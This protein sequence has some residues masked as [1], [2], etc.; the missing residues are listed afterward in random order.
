M[1]RRIKREDYDTDEEYQEA[2]DEMLKLIKEHDEETITVD[3]NNPH[4]CYTKGTI[5]VLKQ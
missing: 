5:K 2:Y 4:I 3:P 1:V